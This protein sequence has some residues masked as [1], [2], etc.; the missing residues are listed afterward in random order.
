MKRI[1]ILG[2]CLVAVLAFCAMVTAAAQAAEV[3]SCVKVAKVR[4]K[5]KRGS[6]KEKAKG[7]SEGKYRNK[8][9]SEPA[10]ENTG[11]YPPYEGPEGKYERRAEGAKFFTKGSKSLRAPRFEMAG[12]VVV[13]CASS[14]GKGGWTGPK[15]GVEQV[16]FK[17]C[18][19][20]TTG[21]KCTSTAL[22]PGEIE[23]SR[24]D[25]TL[26]GYPEELVQEY[27]G[28]ENEVIE[29]EET[30]PYHWQLLP[31]KPFVKSASAPGAYY[32]E[33]ACGA[34]LSYRTAGTVAGRVSTPLNAEKK[35]M[36]WY[37]EPGDNAQDLR[38]EVSVNGGESYTPVGGETVESYEPAATDK[39]GLEVIEEA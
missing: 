12:G 38:S 9:C 16:V 26:I 24:L 37:D 5:Y 20:N 21:E 22:A 15:T 13:H 39:A 35:K 7:I 19:I 32:M 3:T 34:D 36:D 8:A 11:K 30:K 4:V 33:Y 10:P 28:E 6:G 25:L 1:G 17:G 27:L 31:G 2:L 29:N 18:V 14:S 23:T